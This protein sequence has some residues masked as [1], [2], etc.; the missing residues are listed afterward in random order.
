[1][2]TKPGGATG[3][4]FG[5]M[6]LPEHLSKKDNEVIIAS[7]WSWLYKFLQYWPTVTGAINFTGK[8]ES[9]Y[10]Q[11]LI[12]IVL[13]P[14]CLTFCRENAVTSA[15]SNSLQSQWS[16]PDDSLQWREFS[17]NNNNHHHQTLGRNFLKQVMQVGFLLQN[18][19]S[20]SPVGLPWEEPAAWLW[21]GLWQSPEDFELRSSNSCGGQLESW[22]PSYLWTLHSGS[23]IGPQSPGKVVCNFTE[24]F[25]HRP[26]LRNPQVSN[27]D[28][29]IIKVCCGH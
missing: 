19:F 9:T 5:S 11:V 1:M 3:T 29:G 21:N 2:C 18:S 4:G 24:T 14:E 12:T 16:R 27:S 6:V 8:P 13:V 28:L 25:I 26:Q 10:F 7:C 20:L 15:W 22:V 17:L 23:F